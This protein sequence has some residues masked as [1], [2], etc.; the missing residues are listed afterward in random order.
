MKKIPYVQRKI[1]EELSK[2]R[3]GIREGMEKGVAG[4]LYVQRLP[5]EGLSEVIALLLSGL[6]GLK[7]TVFVFTMRTHFQ[8]CIFVQMHAYTCTCTIHTHV[9][10]L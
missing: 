4:T 10:I 7:L 1:E 8:A 9:Y 3:Q 6:L 5:T 2:A